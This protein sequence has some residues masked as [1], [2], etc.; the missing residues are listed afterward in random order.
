M[1]TEAK[2][3]KASY[4]Y[5]TGKLKV[6]E[7]GK[8]RIFK[9]VPESE[10]DKLINGLERN[11]GSGYLHFNKFL[12]KYFDKEI[13]PSEDWNEDYLEAYRRYK[14]EKDEEEWDKEIEKEYK[15]QQDQDFEKEFK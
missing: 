5:Y 12:S 13:K 10:C 4:D 3:I 14:K 11:P 2:E 6:I 7:K 9:D 8:T 15:K 1:I